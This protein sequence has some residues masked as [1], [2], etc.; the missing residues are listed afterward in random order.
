MNFQAHKYNWEHGY[1]Y[2]VRE[3]PLPQARKSNWGAVYRK[4]MEQ[5]FNAAVARRRADRDRQ[6]AGE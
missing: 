1:W 2:R 6:E 4:Y 3:E 5:D